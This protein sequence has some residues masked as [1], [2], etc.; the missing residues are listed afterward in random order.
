MPVLCGEEAAAPVCLDSVLRLVMP[1]AVVL[2]WR[3]V[4]GPETFWESLL[5]P[6]VHN[7]TTS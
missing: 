2:G 5:V 4:V 3:W 7:L 6:E 1:R